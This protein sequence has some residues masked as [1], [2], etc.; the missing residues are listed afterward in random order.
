M[1][2]SI[3]GTWWE[4]AGRRTSIGAQDSF[5]HRSAASVALAGGLGSAGTASPAWQSWGGQIFYMAAQGFSGA[6]VKLQGFFCSSLRSLRIT[7]VHLV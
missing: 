6:Q 1:W 2:F 4:P 7:P 3:E 5:T